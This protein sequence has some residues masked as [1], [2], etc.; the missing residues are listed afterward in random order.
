MRC[1]EIENI[2]TMQILWIRK[3]SNHLNYMICTLQTRARPWGEF[4]PND[5]SQPQI[6]KAKARPFKEAA[7]FAITTK[8]IFISFIMFFILKIKVSASLEADS[9]CSSRRASLQN[10][11]WPN[12]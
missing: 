2:H 5:R 4:L 1:L 12:L 8:T 7:E 9:K 6:P 11:I 3:F 10:L